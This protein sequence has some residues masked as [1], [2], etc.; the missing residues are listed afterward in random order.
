VTGAQVIE[1][2][3]ARDPQDIC[4][5]AKAGAVAG[6]RRDVAQR[7]EGVVQQV[8]G[9]L[10]VAHLGDQES[11]H[12]PRITEIQPLEGARIAGAPA[13]QEGGLLGGDL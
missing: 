1:E 11:Q 3:V 9:L 12:D 5:Q 4:V 8:L 2:D 13:L 10:V 7:E 6:R